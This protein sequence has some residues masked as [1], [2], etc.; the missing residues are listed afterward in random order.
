M[1]DHAVLS[2]AVLSLS[3]LLATGMTRRAV[4]AA[5]RSGA[6]IRARRDHYLRGTA[7]HAVVEAVRV[8]GRLTCLSLLQLLGVFVY[9]NTVTH[10]H[11]IR[12]AS[13]LRSPESADRPIELRQRR[14]ARLHWLPLIRPDL[15]RTAG[16]AVVDAV[17]H[18]VLC[19]PARHAIATIDSA[20]NRGLI[21]ADDLAEIFAALPR[22]YAVLRRLVD[23]RAQSGTE[24]L[25]RLLARAMG[26]HVELQVYFSGVGYVDLLLDG[27]LV[28]ECDSR[29]FHEDWAQQ[30]KD[31]ERDLALAA[32]GLVTL[33]V[34]A[35][36]V[37]YRPDE[38]R[39][40]IRGLRAAHARCA[41]A[42]VHN[43]I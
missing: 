2:H 12:G 25:M 22:K 43:S 34:T 30:V 17:T 24:T 21:R 33:R 19:Q 9:S 16:V 31:R 4:T 7:P 36:Q 32:R 14:S 23:G 27:W 38:V 6:L 39:A 8:G 42:R 35:A 15:A 5:V 10:V 40:A 37:L 18:A 11:V 1:S 26:S 13:R 20:L 3:D 28:V 29:E 41:T